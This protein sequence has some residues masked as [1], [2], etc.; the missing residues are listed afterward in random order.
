MS[1]DIGARILA[2]RT[3]KG[4]T[5]RD[6]AEPNYTA[7]YVS[8]VENGHR[9][10]SSDAL[11]HF[12]ARLSVD[13]TQLT[14]GRHPGDA[15]CVEIDLL[16]ERQPSRW[17]EHRATDPSEPPTRRAAAEVVLGR[18]SLAAAAPDDAAAHFE[19]ARRLI[20]PTLAH[21]RTP[22]VAGLALCARQQG[23]PGYAAYLL[24]D[25][26]DE[27]HRAGL[28]DPA[29][30]LAVHAVLAV[31]QHDL[32]EDATAAAEAALSLAG[33]AGGV[34]EA[35]LA[36]ARA[37]AASSHLPEA[38]AA[39]AAAS[40]AA[41]ESWLADEIAGAH[42]IRG[43]ARLAVGD[44]A[45]ALSDLTAARRRSAGPAALD[46]VVDLAEVHR[47]L[48]DPATARA[49]LSEVD[50]PA[51][52]GGRRGA[53][54][55]S[56]GAASPSSAAASPSSAAAAPSSAA[57]S[58]SSG[59]ASPSSGAASPSSGA[60]SPSSG[61]A[62][63]PGGGASLSGGGASPGDR[64]G[65][66]PGDVRRARAHRVHALLSQDAGDHEAAE[67]HLRAAI[68]IHRRTGPRRELAQLSLDLADLLTAM[69]RPED[70]LT[71][72]ADGLTAVDR[73]AG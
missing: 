71:V 39:L 51:G 3:G 58:P 56:G 60:A 4:L 31:C 6:L 61:A 13:V 27:L 37:L 36:M 64:A 26:R 11:A 18:R 47:A 55:R 66:S 73:H 19:R 29:S 68:A 5:Q 70:A 57:A 25:H 50:G 41:L 44:L 20:P 42:R 40:A 15:L 21:L 53:A 34:F 10:P 9:V 72:L 2:L 30:M 32:G 54:P 62:S 23:D 38:R 67:R 16:Q 8:S 14:T 17:Y 28:P 59:A 1:D 46:A 63:R 65:G 22:A 45:G 33:A 43:R 52:A 35:H 49:L 69:H 12:A 7:A 24:T 48:G